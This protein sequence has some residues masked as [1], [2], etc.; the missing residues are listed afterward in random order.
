VQERIAAFGVL[1]DLSQTEDTQ[2]PLAG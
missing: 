2:P 1:V